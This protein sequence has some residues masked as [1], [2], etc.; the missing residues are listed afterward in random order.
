MVLQFSIKI[1]TL[2]AVEISVIG[3]GFHLCSHLDCLLKKK[4]QEINCDVVNNAVESNS[5]WS[6]WDFVVD[7]RKR[8]YNP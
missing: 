1:D 8:Y 2:N 5:R 7:Y 6:T 3:I 4:C